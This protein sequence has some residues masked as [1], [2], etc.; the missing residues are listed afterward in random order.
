MLNSFYLAWQYIR[1]Y[2]LRSSI[3]VACI[4]L[5]TFLPMSLQLLLNKSEDILF[6]RASD[7]PLLLGAK[8]SPLD[9]VLNSLYFDDEVPELINLNAEDIIWESKLATAIPLY[10][11]FKTRQAPIIGTSIDYFSYRNLKLSSG[12]YLGLLGE[13]VIGANVA[14]R[15]NLKVGDALLSSPETVF[16]LAGIYP[17]KMKVVGILQAAHSID[18]DAVFVDVKTTWIIEGL[19]HGHENVAQLKDQSVILS[20]DKNI[21]SANAKLLHYNEI[22]T[23][24]I[25]DFHLHGDTSRYPLT[26]IIVN[27]DDEKSGTLLRGRFINH[28]QYQLVKPVI[29]IDGLMESVFRIKHIID[30]VVLFV[31][32]TTLLAIFLIFSLSLRLREKEFATVYKMGGNRLITAYLMLAEIAIIGLIS[33]CLCL[34]MLLIVEHYSTEIVHLLIIQ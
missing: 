32:F 18:D 21:V 29:V 20:Q 19:I 15:L 12:R 22:T 13:A 31:G 7:T 27:P 23:D 24:N 1:F 10:I 11:R 5:I 4:T 9:L 3:L 16:D 34:L 14:K 30:G 25:D 8:G 28:E 6:Q 33:L 17:L 26:A 2:K